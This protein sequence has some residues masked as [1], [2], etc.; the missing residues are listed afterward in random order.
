[1]VDIISIGYFTLFSLSLKKEREP[2]ITMQTN[3]E[4]R[5]SEQQYSII[6]A[7]KKD[8][9]MRRGKNVTCIYMFMVVFFGL[10]RLITKSETYENAGC[11]DDYC[12]Y[13]SLIYC[14]FQP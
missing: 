4:E 13:I 14:C 1:M 3:E 9:K 6:V 5:E 12:F 8:D 7:L 2:A 10:L 11:Y